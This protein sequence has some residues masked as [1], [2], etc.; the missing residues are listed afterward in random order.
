MLRGALLDDYE[1]PEEVFLEARVLHSPR[2]SPDVSATPV[3]RSGSCGGGD[4]D[5]D[6]DDAMAMTITMTMTM[7]LLMKLAMFAVVAQG[8]EVGL[9]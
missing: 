2:F 1:R 9:G 4:D 3:K 7:M 5:D 6:D 8:V